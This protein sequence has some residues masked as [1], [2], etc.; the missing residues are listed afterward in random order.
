MRDA[1]AGYRYKSGCLASIVGDRCLAKKYVFLIK[2][3][4]MDT[5][6]PTAPPLAPLSITSVVDSAGTSIPN[7]GTTQDTEL[8]L[9]GTGLA[10][11]VVTILDNGDVIG[12][13]S[14]TVEGLWEISVTVA[15][16]T[17]SFTARSA[18][19]AV[20]LP[21]VI[22]VVTAAVKPTINSV[23]DSKGEVADGGA[24]FETTVT[25]EGMAA[26]S[27]QVEVV[28]GAAALGTAEVDVDGNWALQLYGLAYARHEIKTIGKYGSFPESET[29]TFDVTKVVGR[30]DF[31]DEPVRVLP[32]YTDIHF[33]D[34]L[35]MTVKA[36]VY[37]VITPNLAGY[38]GIGEKSLLIPSAAASRL[39]F[40]RLVAN[41][42]LSYF[43]AAS[44]DNKISFYDKEGEVIQIH[45]MRPA[46][47]LEVIVDDIKLTLSCAYCEFYLSEPDGGF[48]VDNLEWY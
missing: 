13:P 22:T 26:A 18:D 24:T 23:R 5:K 8:T 1:N 2:V 46:I 32:P 28:E 36:D 30:E 9:S 27:E 20:A 7:P 21:W 19:G 14:V 11:G 34:G 35:V 37:F 39:D 40:G 6:I 29:R 44:S 45:S 41:F 47:S 48:Y 17:H 43:G 3:N 16:G 31:E 15:L 38:P 4:I 12:R 10:G 42:K 33:S 25:L